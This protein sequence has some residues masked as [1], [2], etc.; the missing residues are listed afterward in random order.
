MPKQDFSRC[1]Y[2]SFCNGKSFSGLVFFLLSRNHLLLFVLLL[3]TQK[4]TKIVLLLLTLDVQNFNIQQ[5]F[6]E[7]LNTSWPVWST[8][9]EKNKDIM[10]NLNEC[11]TSLFFSV[12]FCM[13]VCKE[14]FHSKWYMKNMVEKLRV[15][16]WKRV[17]DIMV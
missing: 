16:S 15:I 13:F 2:R 10:V 12:L 4:W 17:N 6:C 1:S 7:R 14:A 9:T 3:N 8:K 11:K 5:Q